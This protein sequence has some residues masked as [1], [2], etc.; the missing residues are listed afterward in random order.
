ML[1]PPAEQPHPC[2][3]LVGVSGDGSCTALHEHIHCRNC[4]V[5]GQAAEVA[6]GRAAT[7]TDLQDL[8]AISQPMRSP[9]KTRSAL[10]FRIATDWLALDI[11]WVQEIAPLTRPHAIPHRNRDG[12][13]GLVNVRGQLMLAANLTHLIGEPN[14]PQQAVAGARPRLVIVR[15]KED[16]WAFSAD[17]VPGVMSLPNKSTAPA[18]ANLRAPLSDLAD[19]LT[20][21]DGQPVLWLRPDALHAVLQQTLST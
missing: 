13:A 8:H 6:L 14:A 17:D 1:M 3:R 4:P 16:V 18:P 21:W 11:K 20:E 5:F 2:W 15:W 10:L 9:T 19:G 12:L 7:A